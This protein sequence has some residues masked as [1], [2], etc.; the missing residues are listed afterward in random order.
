M[1]AVLKNTPDQDLSWMPSELK[2]INPK[3]GKVPRAKANISNAPVIK[4]PV[5]SV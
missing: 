2:L 4:L 3:T 1:P 5:V